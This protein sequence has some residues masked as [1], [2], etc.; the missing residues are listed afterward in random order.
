M[1]KK[2]I[3]FRQ[4]ILIISIVLVAGLGSI[5]V[6]LGMDWFNA[7][8]KP[9][10]WIP[11][12]VIP[13][14]WSIVYLSFLVILFL[15]QRKNF[16]PQRTII[17]LAI[18]GFLNV[19]WCLVFF[20]L[21]L[22]FLGNIVIILNLIFAYLL[23]FDIKKTNKIYYYILSIYPVWISIATTLNLALWILN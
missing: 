23:I 8:T 10:Q 17:Y 6:N 1:E 14:V 2:N 9:T 12:I 3:I 21:N 18:N 13:I 5:F 16:L 15:Y 20:T 22:T 19:I 4:I 7:L 11:N